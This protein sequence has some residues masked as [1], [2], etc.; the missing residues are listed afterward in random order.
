MGV[1]GKMI[2]VTVEGMVE[3]EEDMDLLPLLA[4]MVKPMGMTEAAV[5]ALS[6]RQ[7][8]E[9]VAVVLRGL[10]RLCQQVEALLV[11]G[12]STNQ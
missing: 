5:P 9:P 7:D 8:I 2:Q 3:G 6:R 1:V 12:V 4:G 10:A 11:V